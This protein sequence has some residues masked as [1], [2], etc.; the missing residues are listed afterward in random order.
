MPLQAWRGLGRR[1]QVPPDGDRSPSWNQH[2]GGDAEPSIVKLYKVGTRSDRDYGGAAKLLGQADPSA[3]NDNLGLPRRCLDL[4]RGVGR[5]RWRAIG[6]IVRTCLRRVGVSQ[7]IR[8]CRLLVLDGV[9]RQGACDR[10]DRRADG[11]AF[12]RRPGD[13]SEDRAGGSPDTG[14]RERPALARRQRCGTSGYEDRDDRACRK[15]LIQG[16]SP[17]T[18]TVS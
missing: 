11:R 5:V 1:P 4:K 15:T 7:S 6:G 18:D 2:A 3:V 10:P 12:P 13:P 8:P 17:L 14:T 9:A 16:R